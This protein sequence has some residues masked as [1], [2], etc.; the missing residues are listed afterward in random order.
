MFISPLCTKCLDAKIEVCDLGSLGRTNERMYFSYRRVVTALQDGTELVCDGPLSFRGIS[1]K[2]SRTSLT[3]DGRWTV[4]IYTEDMAAS[5]KHGKYDPMVKPD[6]Q[7]C[8]SSLFGWR[9]N[10][11]SF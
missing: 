8:G 10:A 6:K 5:P 2:T 4:N 1:D 9:L 3:A 11:S 7:T